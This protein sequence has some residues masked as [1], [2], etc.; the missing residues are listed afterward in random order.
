[1][2]HKAD[3]CLYESSAPSSD[4]LVQKEAFSFLPFGVLTLC[5]C[6][7][8]SFKTVCVTGE[9]HLQ[10]SC[11][12]KTHSNPD[13]SPKNS[14]KPLLRAWPFDSLL[15]N[16][17]TA[18]LNLILSKRLSVQGCNTLFKWLLGQ[19]NLHLHW[20]NAPF[21]SPA[22]YCSNRILGGA[23]RRFWKDDAY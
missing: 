8:K 17:L 2:N 10:G 3:K 16:N 12:L 9:I 20:R 14:P 6:V 11:L 13:F 15:L 18:P 23:Q 22:Q 5:L 1:M 7:R 4:Y 21:F 19:I